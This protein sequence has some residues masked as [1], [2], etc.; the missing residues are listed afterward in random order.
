MDLE[1]APV[2]IDPRGELS[3]Q[4]RLGHLETLV[5]YDEI[6]VLAEQA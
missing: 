6:S 4:K 3:E 5:A 2:Y 1:D